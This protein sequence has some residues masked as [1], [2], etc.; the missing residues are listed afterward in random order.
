MVR[1]QVGCTKSLQTINLQFLTVPERDHLKAL[2]FT[3]V[4]A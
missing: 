2:H 4:R 1:Q 3:R